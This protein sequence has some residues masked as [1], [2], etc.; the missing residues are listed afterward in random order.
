MSI[1]QLSIQSTIG[2]SHIYV[3]ESLANVQNY[4][5]KNKKLAI[6]TDPTVYSLYGKQ[7]PKSDVLVQIPE[8]ESHKVLSTLDFIF[9]ALVEAEFDRTSFILAIGGGIV[10]DIAGFAAATFMRGIEF[11]FVSTTLLSQV[12]ASVGGKNG[13]NFKGLKNIIGTF[14]LPHFVICELSMLHSLSHE[15][16]LSGMAEV[17]KH[18]AIADKELFSYI[19]SYPEKVAA[20]DREALQKFVYDSVVIKSNIVNQDAKESGARRFFNFGHTFGH[21]IEKI[22][23]IPHGFAVSI[24]MVIAAKLS[25]ARGLLPQAETDRL[26]RVLES[27]GL[28]THIDFD[29]KDLFDALKHDKKRDGNAIHFVLLKEI[30]VAE[31]EKIT[32]DDLEKEF[33]ALY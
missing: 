18:G 17:V 29:H 7:F 4:I 26:I 22:T 30:G 19:E 10:C 2:D 23:K 5:P 21:A 33:Y 20:H 8:G 32:L 16:L 13:V 6:V 12:D 9:D 3:G 28:P 27:I 11:G 25:T 15:E 14:N 24:G 31:V 1:K